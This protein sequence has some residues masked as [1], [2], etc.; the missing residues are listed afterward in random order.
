MFDWKKGDKFIVQDISGGQGQAKIG[1]LLVV[2]GIEN[3]NTWIRDTT[4]DYV[5]NLN[6]IKHAGYPDRYINI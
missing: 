3:N 1:E 5:W 6:Q 4:H 2:Q